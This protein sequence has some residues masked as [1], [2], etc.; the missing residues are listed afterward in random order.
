ML[1]SPSSSGKQKGK[2]SGVK[3][4][5]NNIKSNTGT[6]DLP[7]V[8]TVQDGFIFYHLSSYKVHHRNKKT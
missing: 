3:E 8:C 6:E 1:C 5:P 7:E 4:K 2:K